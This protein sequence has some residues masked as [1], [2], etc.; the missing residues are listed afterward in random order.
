MAT[1]TKGKKNPHAVALGKRLVETRPA[2]YMAEIGTRGGKLGG[3]QT[4]RRHGAEHFAGAGKKGGR[5]RA[6]KLSAAKRSEI[7]RKAVAARWARR[8]KP[9]S[10]ES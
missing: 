9:T 4:L 6:K 7:R 2:D 1:K 8:Q 5:A 10:N 3:A